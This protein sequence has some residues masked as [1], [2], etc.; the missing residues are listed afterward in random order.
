[1]RPIAFVCFAWVWLVAAPA[2][3]ADAEKLDD[4]TV[5][6]GKV[7]TIF[8]EENGGDATL[9]TFLYEVVV[10]KVEKAKPGDELKE[11]KVLYAR[12]VRL[13]EGVK[14]PE[15]VSPP[16]AFAVKPAKGETVRV[17]CDRRDDGLYRVRLNL[18]A[19]KVIKSPNRQ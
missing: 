4:A 13:R 8:R 1:M 12:A 11:G 2:K 10:E 7:R 14:I 19:I 6:Q 17:Y 18:S 9:V 3:A 16:M 15:G 5:V